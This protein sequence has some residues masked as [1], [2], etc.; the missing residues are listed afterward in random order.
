MLTTIFNLT[1]GR[2][3]SRR[4]QSGLL[5]QNNLHEVDAFDWEQGRISGSKFQAP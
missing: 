3:G 1:T 4:S 2:L 5:L